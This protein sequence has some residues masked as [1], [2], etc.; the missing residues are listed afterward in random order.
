MFYIVVFAKI[1]L[2]CL[3]LVILDEFEIKSIPKE[4]K[5]EEK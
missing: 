4:N 3:N 1:Q 5:K 2:F